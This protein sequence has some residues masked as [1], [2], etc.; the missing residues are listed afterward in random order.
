M[1]KIALDTI[2]LKVGFLTTAA[3][4]SAKLVDGEVELSVKMTTLDRK[5]LSDETNTI[6]LAFYLINA[7]ALVV[8][9]RDIAPDRLAPSEAFEDVFHD[10]FLSVHGYYARQHKLEVD[11][12]SFRGI[13]TI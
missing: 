10:L 13:C 1:F 4:N 11:T 2:L 8:D 9:E 3:K 6:E 5:V 7:R 12:V